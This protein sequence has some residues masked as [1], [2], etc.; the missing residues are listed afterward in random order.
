M[1]AKFSG[2]K[3]LRFTKTRST[4]ARSKVAARLLDGAAVGCVSEAFIEGV[5]I[6]LLH[7]KM[8]SLIDGRYTEKWL[9]QEAR[10]AGGKTR[11]KW[12][13][14]I[15]AL[16]RP[17]YDDIRRQVDSDDGAASRTLADF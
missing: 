1:A 17:I 9:K 2:C 6:G 8:M 10:A 3:P 5:R 15:E 12:S 7:E 14:E 16:A 4:L 13:P 11:A